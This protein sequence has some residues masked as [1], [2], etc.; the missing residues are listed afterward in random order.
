MS[1]RTLEAQSL[2]TVEVTTLNQ[3]FEPMKPASSHVGGSGEG[4]VEV[5]FGS[6]FALMHPLTPFQRQS[7][8]S[9]GTH[10]APL[11]EEGSHCERLPRMSAG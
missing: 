6:P 2:F 10:H 11:I 5:V 1:P 7:R 8:H 4:V 9:R 3:S